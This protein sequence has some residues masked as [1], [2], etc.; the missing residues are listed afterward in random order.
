MPNFSFARL[1][2]IALTVLA[3][4]FY[5]TTVLAIDPARLAD[6]PP[7]RLLASVVGWSLFYALLLVGV[8]L[9]FVYLVHSS[10]YRAASSDAGLVIWGQA[11]IAKYLPGNVLHFAGRQVIGARF[12][13]PQGSIAAASLL[14][15]ALQVLLPCGLVLLLL[16]VFGRWGMI[17]GAGAWLVPVFLLSLAG[18]AVVLFSSHL[19]PWLPDRVL[20]VLARLTLPHPPAMAPAVVWYLAFFL[21]MCLIVCSL[22]AM[23]AGEIVLHQMPLLMVAFLISWVMGFAVPGAPGGIGVREGSFALLGG[24][25]FPMDTLAIVALLMRVVTLLGEGVIFLVALQVARSTALT[26]AA[27]NGAVPARGEPR[28]GHRSVGR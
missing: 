2:G 9:G 20:R 3:L 18:M 10:G 11:N 27:R 8:T 23:V 19:R 14:E 7:F 24:A 21:G 4:G 25:F 1:A 6:L 15:I 28:A 12:G 22:H 16:L 26:D 13:W 17:G 5:A